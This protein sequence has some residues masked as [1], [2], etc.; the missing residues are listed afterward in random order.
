MF[1]SMAPE[2]M[3]PPYVRGIVRSRQRDAAAASLRILA[4]RP[5]RVIFAYGQWFERDGAAQL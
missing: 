5:E 4:L 2:A 1:G 3:P